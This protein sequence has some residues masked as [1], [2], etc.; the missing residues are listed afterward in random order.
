M[1]ILLLALAASIT[2]VG[3]QEKATPVAPAP[4]APGV[5]GATQIPPPPQAP[6]TATASLR[7]G[8]YGC[9]DQDAHELPT[10]QFGLLDGSNY[11]DFDGGHGL[12]SFDPA[13]GILTFTSGQFRGLRRLKDPTGNGF[14]VLDENGSKTAVYCP[15]SAK[16][17]TKPHW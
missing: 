17:P 5:Q 1:R 2:L 16:D 7:P 6:N 3:C 4:A 8:V 9:M 10:L 11:S 15:W 13:S 14:T 12:Y